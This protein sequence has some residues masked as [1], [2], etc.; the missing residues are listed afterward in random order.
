MILICQLSDGSAVFLLVGLPIRKHMGWNPK[1][2]KMVRFVNLGA[3]FL[4]SESPATEVIVVMAVGLTCHLKVS[5]AYF[6]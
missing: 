6:F 5:L 1:S 2:Q 3:E 4:A